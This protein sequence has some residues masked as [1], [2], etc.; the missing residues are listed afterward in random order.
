MTIKPDD[1]RLT[2]YALG[3]LEEEQSAQLEALLKENPSIAA[4][5]AA[6]REA[7][8]LLESELRAASTL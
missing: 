1:Q 2:A 4:E 5:V 8:T 6:I 3:E 7:A